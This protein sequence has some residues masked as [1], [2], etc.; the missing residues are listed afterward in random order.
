M[1]A[2]QVPVGG[3][4]TIDLGA[5]AGNWRSI[6]A[7]AAGAETSAV[8]K[9]DG[10]GIGIEPAVR[11]LAAAGCRSFFVALPAEGARARAV[12]PDAE[13]YVLAGLFPESAGFY[14]A[15]DLR[16]VLGSLPEVDEWRAEGRGAPAALHID[17][18]MN[19]LGLTLAEAG[20]V[21]SADP[22]FVPALL[23]SH[24]ACADEPDHALNALQVARFAEARALF[25][26][27]RAS[28]A[29]SA[30]A[31]LGRA[32]R[33][34]L[35]RPG[36]ALYGGQP[37]ADRMLPTRPVV[38]LAGTILL[39]RDVAAGEPVGYGAAECVSRPSRIAIVSLG[40]ADGYLRSAGVLA[41]KSGAHAAISGR[42]IPLVGRVSMDLIAVDVTDV[43]AADAGR[44][45][46]VE[47]FGPQVPLRD[48]ATVA[49]TIDYEFLTSLGSRYARRYVGGP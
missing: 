7:E 15:H 1:T 30:G 29:N 40:Y 43:P 31:F 49:G 42:P 37:F 11:A 13:I 12:A 32:Y 2:S 28:L 18:G 36:V 25:P 10:Y 14:H 44:G 16:P 22:G 26:D 4:L 8:V 20:H 34:D 9:A 17:T 33:H 24:L 38:T 27:V 19:R 48:V 45:A 39:V 6:A 41:G 23:M 3:V 46:E 35:V 21:G 5:L 47:L